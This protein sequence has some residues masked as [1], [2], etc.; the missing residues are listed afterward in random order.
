MTASITRSLIRIKHD[1]AGQ[2]CRIVASIED[3]VNL[4]TGDSIF[5]CSIESIIVEEDGQSLAPSTLSEQ[6]FRRLVR[7]VQHKQIL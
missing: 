5:L 2:A 4:S 1:L 6:E 7:A 3:S